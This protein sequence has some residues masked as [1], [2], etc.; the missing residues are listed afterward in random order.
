MGSRTGDALPMLNR[1]K[2]ELEEEFAI[3]LFWDCA[4]CGA[5]KSGLDEKDA[6]EDLFINTFIC[7]TISGG[8]SI[9]VT[10]TGPDICPYLDVPIVVADDDDVA[11]VGGKYELLA[12]DGDMSA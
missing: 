1:D 10:S 6:T 9:L 11:G 8:S 4:C 3:S 7:A 2:E 5:P 12:I